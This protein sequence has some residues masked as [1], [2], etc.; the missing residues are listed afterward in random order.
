LYV[1]GRDSDEF[2]DFAKPLQ[3]AIDSD[4]LQPQALLLLAVQNCGNFAASDFTGCAGNQEYAEHLLRKILDNH[5]PLWE[6]D[7]MLGT[8]LLKDDHVVEAQTH[9]GRALRAAPHSRQTAGHVGELLL[10]AGLRAE[11][12]VVFQ[13]AVSRGLWHSIYQRPRLAFFPAMPLLGQGFLSEDS[14]PVE[15]RSIRARLQDNWATLRSEALAAIVNQR[16]AKEV[17]QTPAGEWS[18]VHVAS[19]SSWNEDPIVGCDLGVF[20]AICNVLERIFTEVPLALMLRARLTT[21]QPPRAVITG[22]AAAAQGRLSLQCHLSVPP[23]ATNVLQVGQE[24]RNMTEEGLCHW[25]DESFDHDLFYEHGSEG[26]VTLHVD[27]EHPAMRRK[28]TRGTA[29]LEPEVLSDTHWL[30]AI[31]RGDKLRQLASL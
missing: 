4:P 8:I 1:L 24:A 30:Q 18:E 22:H 2:G 12:E 27:V 19:S 3:D 9:L 7:L 26:R 15:L 31:C 16:A 20:P 21:V 6:A 28:S 29:Q 14:V 13:G 23:D 17:R 25:F 5:G 10:K 11:A